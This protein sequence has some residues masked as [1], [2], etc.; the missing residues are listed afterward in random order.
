[1]EGEKGKKKRFDRDFKMSA[2]KMITEGVDGIGVRSPLLTIVTFRAV[3][4]LIRSF[5]WR[6]QEWRP[7]PL[8]MS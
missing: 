2:V 8:R 1:M 5:Y 7:D 3:I 6:C 4:L